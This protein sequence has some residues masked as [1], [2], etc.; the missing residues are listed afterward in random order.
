M[1]IVVLRERQTGEA[2]VALMPESVRKLAALKA[3]V[4]VES[5]AGTTAA[6]SDEDFTEAGATI[7][8]NRG[9]LLEA[10][11]VLVA[12]NRPGD[13]DFLRLKRGAVVIGFLR[14][15]DEPAALKPALT[16]ELTTFA[17]ELVPRITRAQ[18]MDALSS[19]ATVAGYKAVITAAEHLPRTGSSGHSACEPEFVSEDSDD[20]D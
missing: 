9:E 11:D 7:S 10:A 14:P 5:G 15:L 3:S 13:E 19:M 18:S 2:R 6:R 17:M 4:L 12:V 20:E 1:N 16:H 8:A